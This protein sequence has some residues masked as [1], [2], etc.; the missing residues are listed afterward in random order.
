MAAID[1]VHQRREVTAALKFLERRGGTVAGRGRGLS[2]WRVAVL[3]GQ[4]GR[5]AARRQSFCMA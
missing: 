5:G 1:G 3:L 4:L 2:F